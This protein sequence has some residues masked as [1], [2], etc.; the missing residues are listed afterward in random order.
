MIYLFYGSDVGKVRERAFAF[1][2]GARAKEPNLA[3]LRLAG[4]EITADALSGVA[5]SRGLFV[6]RVL[7][8]VDDPFFVDSPIE[9]ALEVLA[10]SNNAIVVI[11]PKLLAAR[12]KKLLAKATKA[13]E[14]NLKEK[15]EGRGFNFELVNALAARSREKLW[16][17]LMLALRA[18]DAPEMLHGL[19][20]WKARD[21][22]A[23]GARAY[24]REEAR[25][26]SFELIALLQNSRRSGVN[27]AL[28]LEKFALSV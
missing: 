12:A 28:A 24:T 7:A 8:L 26:L 10:A 9:A 20:H 11:A 2:A 6:S 21:M 22:L 27:L 13:Y 18:G 1:V 23:K 17:E 5:T 15:K 19:L 16:L 14:Y 25:K 4:E 3:Y